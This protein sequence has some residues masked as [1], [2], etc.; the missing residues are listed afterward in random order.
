MLKKIVATVIGSA[1]AAVLAAPAAM[2][3]PGHDKSVAKKEDKSDQTKTAEKAKQKKAPAA[4]EK[5]KPAEGTKV[6]S[7]KVVE[8]G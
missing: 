1:F 7:K 6:V 2:A 5:A 4:P 3:C 8:K